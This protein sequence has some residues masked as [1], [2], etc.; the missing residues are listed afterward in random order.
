[1]IESVAAD[2]QIQ[3]EPL[4]QTHDPP[5]GFEPG[6]F[7]YKSRTSRSVQDRDTQII[8]QSPARRSSSVSTESRW[9]GTPPSTAVS[10]VPQVPSAQDDRTPTPASSTTS[11]IERSGGIVRVSSLA[12]SELRLL[13]PPDRSILDVVEE[14]GVGVL[15]SCAEGTCGTCETAVLGGLPDHRDSVLTEDERRAGDCMM[16]CVS[17][18][19]TARLVLDL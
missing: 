7:S 18:S 4:R 6:A 11:R 1:M 16:I 5:A 13:V 3:D 15:S 19:C 2:P 17:R 14:A 8:M 10:Q 9:S 12:A